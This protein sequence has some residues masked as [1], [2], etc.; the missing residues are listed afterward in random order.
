LFTISEWRG[1][2]AEARSNGS[3]IYPTPRT[4]SLGFELGF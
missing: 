1:F 4:I 2:D 3:R